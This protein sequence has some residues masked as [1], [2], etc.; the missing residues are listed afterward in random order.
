MKNLHA[1]IRAAAWYTSRNHPWA[2][3]V[4]HPI[5]IVH[6]MVMH[7]F[8]RCCSTHRRSEAWCISNC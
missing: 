6:H 2:E 1:P 7:L 3:V 5:A 8:Q 4:H